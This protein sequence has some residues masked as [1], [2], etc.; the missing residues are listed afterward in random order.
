MKI[1]KIPALIIQPMVIVIPR[2]CHSSLLLNSK[3]EI[4]VCLLQL[5]SIPITIIP[6][7]EPVQS[8]KQYTAKKIFQ[9]RLAK[10]KSSPIWSI[11]IDLSF[12]LSPIYLAQTLHRLKNIDS[13][14]PAL[15]L[16]S[17]STFTRSCLCIHVFV[18]SVSVV[19]F[20]S[21]ALQTR[22]SYFSFLNK[23]FEFVQFF[24]ITH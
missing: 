18:S 16:S 2:K 24:H 9:F 12:S 14:I 15:F 17:A 1:N 6:W 5:I 19:C 13:P 21:S 23:I 7:K 11:L 3:I 22:C 8:N 4:S 10:E 20:S